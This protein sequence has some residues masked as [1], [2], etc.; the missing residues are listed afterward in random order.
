M[1]H[2]KPCCPTWYRH[3][4]LICIII[5]YSEVE[6]YKY[7]SLAGEFVVDCAPVFPRYSFTDNLG[8]SH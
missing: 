4:Q 8:I 3:Q 2:A 1:C 7:G 6:A 5:H